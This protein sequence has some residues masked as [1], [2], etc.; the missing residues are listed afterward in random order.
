MTRKS[1]RNGG[2]MTHKV[3][4][5]LDENRYSELDRKAMELGTSVSFIIRHLVIRYLESERRL[6][7]NPSDDFFS[8]IL[9]VRDAIKP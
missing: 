3:T 4:I 8:H 6:A 2:L 7:V 5:R 1:E 9:G